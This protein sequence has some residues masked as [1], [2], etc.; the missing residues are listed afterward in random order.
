M[1]HIKFYVVE[2]YQF[3]EVYFITHKIILGNLLYFHGLLFF[4][5]LY[6]LLLFFQGRNG[7]MKALGSSLPSCF[8][9]VTRS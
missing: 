6:A 3:C 9:I 7:I 5:S 8:L 2:V 1:L 4:F